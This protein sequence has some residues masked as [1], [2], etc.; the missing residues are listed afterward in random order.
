L[1]AHP[2]SSKFAAFAG[3]YAQQVRGALAKQRCR[4]SAGRGQDQLG[5]PT[6][7]HANAVGQ[8]SRQ[9]LLDVLLHGELAL[10]SLQ[11]FRHCGFAADDLMQVAHQGLAEVFSSRAA[12]GPENR[13]RT[14]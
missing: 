14:I 10:T 13:G 2:Y 7:G 8:R 5:R 6:V 9:R 12:R 3:E 4:G 11:Q 1:H